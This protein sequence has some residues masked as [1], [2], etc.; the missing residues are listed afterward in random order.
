MDRQT[1]KELLRIVDKNYNE[2]ADQYHETRKK[3]LQPLW[4]RLVRIAEKIE[5]GS[6]VL[7]VGCGN[8]R[9]LEALG[10]KD[11][12]YVGVDTNEKL[13]THARGQYPDRRFL[14][15]D[16]LNLGEVPELDFDYVFAI[17]VLHHIP[18]RQ[19]QV[20]ALKQMRNKVKKDGLIVVTVWNLWKQKKHRKL[21]MRYGLL[22]LI[23][24]NKMDWG[25]IIFYWKNPQGEAVSRRY[26]HA[27]TKRQLKKIS[28]R[29]GLAVDA[30]LADKH[31]YYLLLKSRNSQ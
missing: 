24:K 21:I 1:Q 12:Q 10:E 23:G 27:F 18:G 29:A 13:L 3:H 5:P 16:I 20:D 4:D 15:A 25:D 14:K 11:I 9:L 28:R 17:A 7:D 22:K 31:N 8:G 2:I 19:M 30:V 6:A 26:Y